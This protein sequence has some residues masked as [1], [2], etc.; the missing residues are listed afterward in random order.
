MA[1]DE[2][3]G[4]KR[5]AIAR[6]LYLGLVISAG[7]AAALILIF[8]AYSKTLGRA[9][10]SFVI[11][12]I[13][14]T[15]ISSL[16]VLFFN[17][18]GDRIRK[19]RFPVDWI[20]MITALV[21]LSALGCLM[22][23]AMLAAAGLYEWQDYWAI[24]FRDMRYSWA[25]AIAIGVSISLYERLREKLEATTLELREKELA[26]ERAR[27][28]AVEARLSSLESRIHPH[29]LFNTLNSISSL[30]QEYPQQAERLV[31]RL[32]AL[33]RFSLDANQQSFVPLGQE[34]KITRDYLEIEKARIGPRLRYSID[35]PS[36]LESI[37][38]PPLSV[39]TLVE[40]SLK[41]AIAPRRE[42]GEIS[43][44][45]RMIEDRVIIE[46]TDDGPGFAANAIRSGHGLDNLQSRLAALFDNRAA[47]DIVSTGGGATVSISLPQSKARAT[48]TA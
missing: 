41:Y 4:K 32:A 42:G 18:F 20:V 36:T 6:D 23:G 8:P 19:Q 5:S 34:I 31:E 22:A 45:A 9:A 37:E 11:G 25:I 12:L 47:L 3:Q 43:V 28:L 2:L 35:L 38:T 7:V 29:F 40:N 30:I 14:G 48:A 16:M 15:S 27:K 24:F 21:F 26:A 17:L 33:L 44:A 10:A 39:Q 13:Y 46:V 1:A